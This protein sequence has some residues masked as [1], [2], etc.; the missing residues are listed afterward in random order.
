MLYT[1]AKDFDGRREYF[2]DAKPRR[3]RLPGFRKVHS[4]LPKAW[5]PWPSYMNGRIF[6]TGNGRRYL[7][8][9]KGWRRVLP[10]NLSAP[11]KGL[12]KSVES[13]L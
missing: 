3:F 11:Q 10:D 2:T 12:D 4:D 13:V 9:P 7:V 1:G 8:S 5:E 6:T